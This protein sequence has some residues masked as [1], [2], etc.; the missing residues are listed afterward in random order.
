[1]WQ[2]QYQMSHDGTTDEVDL[3]VSLPTD[4][5][6]TSRYQCDMAV[7][8][9]IIRWWYHYQLVSLSSVTYDGT[10]FENK[11]EIELGCMNLTLELNVTKSRRELMTQADSSHA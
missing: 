11:H 6:M 1:M 3:M 2:H 7:S 10:N 4:S 9:T 8:V 5:G